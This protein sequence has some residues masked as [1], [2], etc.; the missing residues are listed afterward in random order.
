MIL[1]LI[2]ELI[3]MALWYFDGTGDYLSVPASSQFL[4]G[5]NT[6]FT[7]EAWVYLT[8]APSAQGATV[9]GTGEYGTTSDWS[10]AIDS[11]RFPFFYFAVPPGGFAITSSTAINVNSW[12]HIAVTRSGTGSNNLKM[13]LNGVN[14]A[15]ASRNDTMDYTGNNL[16]IGADENGDKFI[17]IDH[18]L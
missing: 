11:S 7:F 9:V 6:D 15:Q 13:F 4:P 14:V 8:A 17:E 18:E 3:G 10:I 2:S 16:S 12:N 1:L 5:V